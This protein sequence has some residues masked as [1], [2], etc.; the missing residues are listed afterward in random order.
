MDHGVVAYTDLRGLSVKKLDIENCERLVKEWHQ[1][2][3]IKQKSVIRNEIFCI[4]K[5]SIDKWVMNI[6]ADKKI[7]IDQNEKLAHVWDCFLHGLRHHKPDK[8]IPLI[9]H[10]F[11]YTRFFMLSK[12]SNMF[13]VDPTM[14]EGHNFDTKVDFCN[15]DLDIALGHLEE[16]RSFRDHLPEHYT[17]IFDDALASMLPYNRDRQI[18]G[19]AESTITYKGYHEVKKVLKCTIEFLLTR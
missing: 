3:D 8:K 17:V 11:A 1:N 4:V 19:L 12:I 2:T 7:Y 9:N 5:P 14:V 18:K 13:T 10:F 16:L 15:H 6:L